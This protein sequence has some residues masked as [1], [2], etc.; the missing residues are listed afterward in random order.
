MSAYIHICDS[1]A[2][3]NDLWV[4]AFDHGRLAFQNCQVNKHP[5]AWRTLARN[6]YQQ[7]QQEPL[8]CLQWTNSHA[9]DSISGWNISRYRNLFQVPRPLSNLELTLGFLKKNL[10][11]VGRKEAFPK[12]PC[13]ENSPISYTYKYVHKYL[14]IHKYV[15]KDTGWK[16]VTYIDKIC[17]MLHGRYKIWSI[18]LN[19][20]LWCNAIEQASGNTE[21]IM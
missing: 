12:T 20:Q 18:H 10:V 8:L 13:K 19:L 7:R 4:N 6:H 15:G 9:D 11:H 1:A 3:W 5:L 14:Q 21:N 2:F 17:L 16:V